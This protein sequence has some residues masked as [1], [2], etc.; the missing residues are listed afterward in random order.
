MVKVYYTHA[1]YDRPFKVEVDSTTVTIYERTKEEIKE[2]I[3][4]YSKLFKKYKV[5]EVHIGKSK[6][7]KGA[8][9]TK[10]GEKHFVGNSIILKLKDKYIFIGHEIYEFT[11]PYDEIVKYYSLIGNND[12]PY[13]V[14]VGKNNVY[15]M[16]D[17]KYVSRDKF[18]SKMSSLEWQDA[19][20]LFYFNNEYESV[21][22]KM[23]NVKMIHKKIM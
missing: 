13:P 9:H 19:Y 3:K 4:K 10:A 2:E 21:V 18:P 22:K 15:F 20:S 1:N 12:V 11:M 14:I 8:D 6:A 5:E 7:G 23:K 17:K 16:L